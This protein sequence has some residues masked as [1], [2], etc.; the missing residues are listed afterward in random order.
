MVEKMKEFVVKGVRRM[1]VALA[2]V[3]CITTIEIVTERGI[4][5]PGAA[6]IGIVVLPYYGSKAAEV[7]P[8][9]VEALK[10]YFTRGK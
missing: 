2:A 7:A 8:Q 6:A 5:M 3:G 1:V 4:T 10:A 9:M